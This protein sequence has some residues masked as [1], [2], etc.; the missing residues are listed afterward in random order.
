MECYETKIMNPTTNSSVLVGESSSSDTKEYRPPITAAKEQSEQISD[1][2]FTPRMT[3]LVSWVS[4][5]AWIF[6]LLILGVMIAPATAS[7]Q[8]LATNSTQTLNLI[9]GTNATINFDHLKCPP[10]AV[11]YYTFRYLTEEQPFCCKSQVS[12]SL[13]SGGLKEQD[14]EARFSVEGFHLDDTFSAILNIRNVSVQDGGWIELVYFLL[15][16]NDHV[17]LRRTA[18]INVLSQPKK[19]KCHFLR[20]EAS[21]HHVVR[22]HAPAEN[23][24]VT[25]SCYQNFSRTPPIVVYTDSDDLIR[26]TFLPPLADQVHCCSH[27]TT[28]NVTQ[29][30]CDHSIFRYPE[31]ILSPISST[32]LPPVID[33][34]LNIDHDLSTEGFMPSSSADQAK[35]SGLTTL[36]LQILIAVCSSLFLT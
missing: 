20:E 28:K 19:V 21:K 1:T 10:P 8:F 6:P 9:E 11:P 14:Q 13:M 30:T 5:L 7:T 26:A 18:E 4:L 29:E 17:F 34:S 2:P 3:F 24:K 31:Q 22:C 32:V 27:L 16:H 35:L 15:N 23:G 12:H 36:C 25:I 33:D